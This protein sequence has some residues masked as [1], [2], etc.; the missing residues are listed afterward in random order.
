MPEPII[1][2]DAPGV[3]PVPP[4]APDADA[5]A[6]KKRAKKAAVPKEFKVLHDLVGPFEKGTPVSAD[7][8]FPGIDDPSALIDRLIELE[9]IGPNAE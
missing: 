3:P 8:L 6:P 1:T 5:P 2:P 9:A 4:P 7:D